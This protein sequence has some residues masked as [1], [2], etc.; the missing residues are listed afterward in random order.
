MAKFEAQLYSWFSLRSGTRTTRLQLVEVK[1]LPATMAEAADVRNERFSLRFR[2]P[3]HP[4][5]AQDTYALDHARLGR[6]D[7][8]IVPMAVAQRSFQRVYEAVFNFPVQPEDVAAQ[9][10]AAPQPARRY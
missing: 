10:S 1:R 2:G 6:L 3:A 5:L 8:F 4:A 9:L 7:I